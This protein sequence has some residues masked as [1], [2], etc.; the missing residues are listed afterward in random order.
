[1][2]MK[3]DYIFYVLAPDFSPFS[4]GGAA[5]H[6]LCHQINALGYKSYISANVINN[7]L[8]TP[9]FNINTFN[10]HRAVGFKQIAIYPEIEFGNPLRVNTSI[11]WLLNKPNFFR[12]N[13]YGEV[14]PQDIYWHQDEE[15]KPW[16]LNSTKQ[17]IW[18][19]DREVFNNNH[20]SP[21]NRE[22]FVLYKHRNKKNIEVPDWVLINDEISMENK[23]TPSECAALYKRSLALI[24][25][26]RTAAHAEAALCGCPTIFIDNDGLYS[27]GIINS[28]FSI[29]SFNDFDLNKI[30]YSNA[31]S[32]IMNELYDKQVKIDHDSLMINLEVAIDRADNNECS[33]V[34]RKSKSI[35]IEEVKSLINSGRCDLAANYLIQLKRSYP[36]CLRINHL[37]A[38]ILIKNRNYIQASEILKNILNGILKFESNEYLGGME[39]LILSELEFCTSSALI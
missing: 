27:K 10:Q 18:M 5:L 3:S 20:Y 26:E 1:M 21:L 9:K 8:S 23:K 17:T 32:K 4:S 33:L 28:I 31:N 16:W 34:G 30:R 11:R 25:Q 24:T 36:N 6:H 12:S 2:A 35:Q 22:N 7:S 38:Q 29:M 14:D 19:L 37:S 15:F 39:R 13:W